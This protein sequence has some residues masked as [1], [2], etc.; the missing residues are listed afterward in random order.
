MSKE[1]NKRDNKPILTIDNSPIR[2][3]DVLSFHFSS[4]S[5]NTYVFVYSDGKGVNTVMSDKLGKGSSNFTGIDLP[6]DHVLEARD[7]FNH[8]ATAPFV[9]LA[10]R[11][12]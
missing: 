1:E 3:K 8:R 5:P 2:Y 12:S 6:D 10:R 11:K 9:V 4:F 7:N